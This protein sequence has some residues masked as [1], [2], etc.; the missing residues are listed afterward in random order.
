MSGSGLGSSGASP[1]LFGCRSA[2]GAD[3]EEAMVGTVASSTSAP[4]ANPQKVE[5][6]MRNKSLHVTTS[7]I[8][9]RKLLSIYS[10]STLPESKEMTEQ[11]Y[12]WIKQPSQASCIFK[13]LEC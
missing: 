11:T 1:R 13:E 6:R 7:D 5:T 3:L 4:S 8:H 10:P 9:H 12:W 2:L